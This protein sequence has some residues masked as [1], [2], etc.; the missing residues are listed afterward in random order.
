MQVENFIHLLPFLYFR[1]SNP[2][3]HYQLFFTKIKVE[4]WVGK[5]LTYEIKAIKE[6]ISYL[7]NSNQ[8]IIHFQR[9]NDWFRTVDDLN[10][11][12]EV[13]TPDDY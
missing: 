6:L 11:I 2:F 9:I 10:H 3:S 1:Q 12:W 8:D 4:R 13:L 7:S 5:I